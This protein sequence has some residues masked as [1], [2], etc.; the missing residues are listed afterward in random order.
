MDN[1]QEVQNRR[2]FT[3]FLH[4]LNFQF[5]FIFLLT[6]QWIIVQQCKAVVYSQDF[7]RVLNF[8]IFLV[9]SQLI[10]VK[11]CKTVVFARIFMSFD[12]LFELISNA[13]DAIEKFRYLQVM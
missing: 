8:S 13:S 11:Q 1:S 12:F 4:A 2:E 10:I 3:R 9:K 7:F 5:F 6:S